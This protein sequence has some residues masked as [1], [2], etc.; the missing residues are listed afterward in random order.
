M[1]IFLSELS[2]SSELILSSKL[3][4]NPGKIV[5][6]IFFSPENILPKRI[7]V[8]YSTAQEWKKVLWN[9]GVK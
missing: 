1:T 7:S 6:V 5:Q 4:D 3:N 2:S 8:H 9:V